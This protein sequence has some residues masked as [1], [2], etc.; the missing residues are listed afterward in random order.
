MYQLSGMAL[1][2]EAMC[3]LISGDP[4]SA[5]ELLDGTV[6]PAL[7]PES[8]LASAYQMTGRAE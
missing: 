4:N 8:L 1:Y 7:P 5:L 6:A 2:M 3:S